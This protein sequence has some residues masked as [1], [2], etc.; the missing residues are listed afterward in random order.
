[1]RKLSLLVICC[2]ALVALAAPATAAAQRRFPPRSVRD[3]YVPSREVSL[4]VGVLSYDPADDKN[5]PMAALR[6]D[7]RLS[8]YIR[9]ELG[10]GYALAELSDPAGA[11]M[12]S[13]LLAAT[14]GLR[15]ELPLPVVRP[16]VG[17]AVGLFGRFDAEDEGDQFV[18]PTQAFPVGVRLAFSQRV[19][20]RG[21]VRFRFD[22]HRGGGSAV[23][24]EKTGGLSFSF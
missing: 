24:V 5:F 9:S 16:Y 15:A 3:V 7:W 14:V 22:E 8:R 12:N 4:V 17:A 18:R 13:S 1:M 19:A 21:E 23:D 11:D 10:F 6:F 2:A 20:L